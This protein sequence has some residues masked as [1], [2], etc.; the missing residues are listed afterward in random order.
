MQHD[1]LLG[2]REAL[3]L[4]LG[5][6]QNVHRAAHGVDV[7]ADLDVAV[8]KVRWEEA[9]LRSPAIP[10]DDLDRPFPV[11][12]VAG[13]YIEDGVRPSQVCVVCKTRDARVVSDLVDKPAA[14]ASTVR[15]N[16]CA[17]SPSK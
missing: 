17:A 3:I 11:R 8:G 6:P 12:L 7:L 4:R 16:V 9:L 14:V 13:Y 1:H 2:D 15:A 5:R 10:L